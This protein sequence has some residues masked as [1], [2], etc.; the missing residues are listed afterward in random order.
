M[1]IEKLVTDNAQDTV[2]SSNSI[3]AKV[4]ESH[5]W[6]YNASKLN[7]DT[8]KNFYK[9]NEK[10]EVIGSI[11]WWKW[12]K[13]FD[14][15][16]YFRVKKKDYTTT[17]VDDVK[18]YVRPITKFEES[19]VYS[20]TI[21]TK[22][23]TFW[24]DK[25][26]FTFNFKP[27]TTWEYII[28]Y[29][30]NVQEWFKNFK[31]II[32]YWEKDA[33][34]PVIDD[35]KV[36]VLSE[37]VVYK[38]WDKANILIR[39]PFSKWKIL[40]TK[41]KNEV[42]ESK[43]IDVYNNIFFT[44][45]DIDD[46]FAPN[47]YIWV[48]AFDT[49]N[50]KV[51]E[52]KVGYTE[53]V[54]DKTDKKSEITVKSNK[55][56]YAPREEVTLNLELKDKYKK[57]LT[58]EISVMVVDDSLISMIGNID[59][60]FIEKFFIKLPFQIQTSITNLAM[61]KN[62]YFS[63]PWIVGWSWFGD[64]KWW[65]SAISTRNI[66]KN[67]AYYNPSIITDKNWKA[68]VKFNL[69]DNL[70]NFRI[71]AISN[72]KSNHFWVSQTNIS[73]RKNIIIEDKTPLMVRLGD[74]LEVWANVFNTTKSDI[75]LVV[76]FVSDDLQ[77]TNISQKIKLKANSKQYVKWNT[78]SNK[79]LEKLNYTI[80]AVWVNK[81]NSD[82][83]QNTID[84]KTSPIIITN[85]IQKLD[86]DTVWNL[87]FNTDNNVDISKTKLTLSLSNFK[88]TWIEKIIKS[89]LQYPYGCIE[90][91]T[92]STL[93]NVIFKR[94][95]KQLSWIVDPKDVEKN[96]NFWV[97]RILWM[98]VS[99]WWFAYWP[100]ESNSNLHITPYVLRSLV[101]MKQSWVNIKQETL[102]KTVEFLKQNYKNADID[103]KAEILWWLATAWI[104]LKEKLN[105]NSLWR[106][107]GLA[108]VYYQ[109]LTQKPIWEVNKNIESIKSTLNFT[110]E[111]Y[112]RDELSDKS[113]FVTLLIWT[114]YSK[115]Y[116]DSL[117]TDIY[118][119]DW[120]SYYY[121][122]QSKNNAFLAFS[123][124]IE[125]Y[126]KFQ[127]SDVQINVG[128]KTQTVKLG[129]LSNNFKML[130]F[131]L[132]DIIKD[133]KVDIS[134]SN[135]S[136]STVYVDWL[137]AKYPLD[138]TKITA[139]QDQVVITRDI[140]EIKDQTKIS[141]CENCSEVYKKVTTNEFKKW[142]MYKIIINA[143]INNKKDIKNFV[144]EDYLPA[145]FS[146]INPK[147]KTNSAELAEITSS[148][149][150][151]DH[152]EFKSD[153]VFLNAS[154]MYWNK[155]KAE[156]FVRAATPW[157]FLYPPVTSYIMYNPEIRGNSEFRKIVIK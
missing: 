143:N 14:W 15:K 62:F 30:N 24:D 69:P 100:W 39:L 67:T 122:T 148:T 113:I 51:P 21:N 18:W 108:Y 90:Q 142:S 98:Q 63:R 130:E 94:I 29:W 140:Y 60:N 26:T 36:Q 116:I 1:I 12:S 118:N 135:D 28:E 88:L 42:V 77:T 35:N 16:Y 112:Y 66:F 54:I 156:Y 104:D 125:K 99:D 55:Q 10:V 84:I 97:D 144:I 131:N 64:M 103:D 50:K 11:S 154:Y 4:P 33:R 110:D 13:D 114:G 17:Y 139:K 41:E 150:D 121:S 65:D 145:W 79:L 37:K 32:I 107:W 22:D 5:K 134:L 9:Q 87:V 43:L 117:I 106:H 45:I 105:F 48:V 59:L 72:S 83:V 78:Q 52:Y 146:V 109:V 7:I 141:T 115:E 47:S 31:S 157:E 81:E 137:L 138:P 61:V 73:V 68:E 19:I 89:L 126:S 102:D 80:K 147:F 74:K 40:L 38:V 123:S 85:D 155:A 133:N 44:T 93:P 76:S 127:E 46:S 95:N 92:S 23:F 151:F 152:K 56:E 2:A 86:L 129:W 49:T 3:I 149:W 27:E 71:I 124:Y 53:V 128:W 58:W 136:S 153:V 34:N 6:W 91:T 111:Y 70:T 75:D 20:W 119:R 96:I 57:P 25:K 82:I 132:K 101:F 120:S 8:S